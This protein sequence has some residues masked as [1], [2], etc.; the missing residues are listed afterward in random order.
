M[1]GTTQFLNAMLF[2]I[3][4]KASLRRQKLPPLLLLAPLWSLAFDLLSSRL[5]ASESYRN[6]MTLA[7][8]TF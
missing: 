7:F 8:S 2:G 3:E 4:P 6:H 1:N 5:H